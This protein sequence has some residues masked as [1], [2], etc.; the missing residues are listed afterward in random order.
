MH[1]DPNDSFLTAAFNVVKEYDPRTYARMARDDSWYVVSMSGDYGYGETLSSANPE[2]HGNAGTRINP[3]TIKRKSKRLDIHPTMFAAAVLVH[4]YRH[5]H[6]PI[7]VVVNT[8]KAESQAFHAGSAFAEKLPSPDGLVIRAI[9]DQTLAT[10]DS[11][12][13]YIAQDAYNNS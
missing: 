3:A 5:A 11:N 13:H 2:L 1:Y 6:Q 12:P 10:M 9:S 7:A 8:D 4:E